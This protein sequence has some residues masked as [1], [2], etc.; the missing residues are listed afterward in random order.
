MVGIENFD[1]CDWIRK[2]YKK[3][4]STTYFDRTNAPVREQIIHFE[5]SPDWRTISDPEECFQKMA[6]ALL[7]AD[8]SEWKRYQDNIVQKIQA[9]CYPKKLKVEK[10]PRFYTTAKQRTACVERLQYMINMPVEGHILGTLWILLF[11]YQID[12]NLYERAYGN[13]IRKTLYNELTDGPTYSPHLFEPYFQQYQSWRDTA[14]EDAQKCV[15]QDCDVVVFTLDLASYYYSLDVTPDV[16]E[17][18]LCEIEKPEWQ[19]PLATRLSLFIAEVCRVYARRLP[20]SECEGRAVLP[21]GFLPSN[22]LGNWFLNRFDQAI[23]DHWNPFYYGRYVDDMLIV[24]KVESNSDIARKAKEGLTKKDIIQFFLLQCSKW[25]GILDDGACQSKSDYALLQ[26]GD[27]PQ[28]YTINPR[29]LPMGSN[30]KISI[31]N[32]KVNIFYFQRGESDA[33]L[34][35]FKQNIGRNVSEFRHMP[36]DDAVFQRNDYHEIYSLTQKGI[37][38]LRDV[39]NVEVDKFQLS[40]FLGKYLRIGGVIDD[41]AEHEFEK[42]LDKIFDYQTAI[43]NYPL[44]ERV[45]EILVVNERFEALTHFTR[46]VREAIEFI[47]LSPDLPSEELEK[48]KDTL[49]RVQLTGVTKALALCWKPSA[50]KFSQ[51][52]MKTLHDENITCYTYYDHDIN[53]KHRA[54]WLRCRMADKSIMSVLPD[55]LLAEESAWRGE[56]GALFW[57]DD[58]NINLSRF[59]DVLQFLSSSEE[60]EL[61]LEQRFTC[62][63]SYKYHPYMLTMHELSMAQMLAQLLA[64]KMPMTAEDYKRQRKLYVESNYR[65]QPSDERHDVIDACPLTFGKR[66]SVECSLVRVGDENKEKLHIALANVPLKTE[67]LIAVLDRRPDRS[68]HRYQTVSK[69]VNQ[70]LD[71]S[72]DML[73]MPEAFLPYEWLPILARTCAK[74]QMAA[75]TGIEH[76]VIGNTVY[77]LTATILPFRDHDN[78]C[79]QIC[80][81]LKNYYAPAELIELQ[82]FHMIPPEHKIRYELFCWNDCW[83]SV[84]C[85]FELCSIQDRAL[86]QSYVDFLVAVE[87]NRDINYYGNIVKALA[88]DMHCYCVQVNE[89]KYGDSRIVIPTRTE[90]RDLARIKGGKNASVLVDEINIKELRDFQ[91]M[92][93]SKVEFKP[94]PPQ[95][96]RDIVGA[97]RKHTLFENLKKRKSIN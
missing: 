97:K 96:N 8:E 44:W 77:N 64:H 62:M 32:E 53:T 75:V 78:L 91:F 86:F 60:Q 38:K 51:D 73:V 80:F 81:H 79:A 68:Y 94:L 88:R 9:F 71:E 5:S 7:S 63:T 49:F 23:V 52:F 66:E 26:A 29:Y 92:K 11:G 35:C 41:P 69:L 82:K 14:L 74:S 33:L 83:F 54:A 22:I 59:E 3:F 4:K 56:E 70:A 34:E 95:F 21:I 25:P 55:F 20:K 67:T 16:M 36:E 28:K 85:C 17:Q 47:T 57:N 1:L 37:N 18:V 24:S 10:E 93:H 6:K 58:L 76:L 84:Y 65:I 27:D 39:E 19:E 2:A 46:R 15:Q 43:N 42:D 61:L 87:W 89:A 90:E 30:C 48:L 72:A 40:K 50:R 13:R 12:Q 45:A 31:Q